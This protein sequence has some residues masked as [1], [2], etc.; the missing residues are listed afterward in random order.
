MRG[1]KKSRNNYCKKT[2]IKMMGIDIIGSSMS[3][4]SRCTYCLP[5]DE[6]QRDKAVSF[7]WFLYSGPFFMGHFQLEISTKGDVF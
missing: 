6:L 3:V 1:K 5:Y 2:V 7:L 4:S